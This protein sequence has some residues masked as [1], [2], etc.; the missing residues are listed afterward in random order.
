MLLET[1]ATALDMWSRC[2]ALGGRLFIGRSHAVS[3]GTLWGR[4]EI[5]PDLPP[6]MH[7]DIPVKLAEDVARSINERQSGIF[8]KLAEKI[9]QKKGT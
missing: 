8:R 5:I 7:T 6:L 2:L 3:M 1:Q 9:E 4:T